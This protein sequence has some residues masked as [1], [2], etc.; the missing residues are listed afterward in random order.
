MVAIVDSF[1]M[2]KKK[3]QNT[4]D[5]VFKSIFFVL[6]WFGFKYLLLTKASMYLLTIQPSFDSGNQLEVRKIKRNI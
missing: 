2:S 6:F 3:N 1:L 5:V 4:N